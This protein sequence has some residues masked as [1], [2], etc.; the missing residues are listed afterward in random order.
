MIDYYLKSGARL[1]TLEILDTNGEVIRQFSSM[2]TPEQLH[3]NDMPHPTYW[4]RPPEVLSNQAGMQRFMWDMRYPPPRGAERGY[5]IAAVH[6]NTPSGPFGPWVQP[7]EYTVRLTIDGQPYEQPL[8]V[9]LDPRVEV[10][11]EALQMQYDYSMQCYRLYHAAQT[12][13]EQ[14]ESL[15]SQVRDYM[16]QLNGPVGEVFENL[17][18]AAVAITGEG[19]PSE[20]DI[21]Y[22]SVYEAPEGEE[23]LVGFQTTL[24]WLHLLLQN[25]DVRPTTQIV[26]A[27]QDQEPIF[28]DLI[29]RWNTLVNTHLK[30]VNDQLVSDGRPP[31]VVE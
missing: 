10:T 25:A 11:D 29:R 3:P 8:T 4:I 24:L 26:Q 14:I 17:D 7:G 20:P 22:S 21:L 27:V 2:D 6:M 13:R 9:R 18:Q 12:V 15:R 1:V 30:T 5:S 19:V 16:E 28:Q 23:T 31:L